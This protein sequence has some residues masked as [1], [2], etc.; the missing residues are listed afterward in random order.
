MQSILIPSK[1]EAMQP[2]I[3]KMEW[4]KGVISRG[5][6]DFANKCEIKAVLERVDRGIARD[7]S[8]GKVKDSLR[9]S[10]GD[11]ALQK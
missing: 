6:L 11:D 5:A 3:D 2:Y 4:A 1:A 7:F 10:E 8:Y 9:K